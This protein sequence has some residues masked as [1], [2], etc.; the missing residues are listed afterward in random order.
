MVLR[1]GDY[2]SKLGRLQSLGAGHS[3]VKKGADRRVPGQQLVITLSCRLPAPSYGVG[4]G[5]EIPTGI[6]ALSLWWST[7][8]LRW[9]MVGTAAD[10]CGLH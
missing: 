1:T 3:V 10:R 8:T 2:I 5:K 6:L 7:V 4:G 9:L